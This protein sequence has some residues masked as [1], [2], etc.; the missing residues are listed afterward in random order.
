MG[1]KRPIRLNR[2]LSEKDI[3]KIKRVFYVE[4]KR[5]DKAREKLCIDSLILRVAKHFT[6]VPTKVYQEILKERPYVTV[7]QQVSHAC[8]RNEYVSIPILPK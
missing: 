7:N 1:S 8:M 2:P 3:M 4:F 5:K 6:G